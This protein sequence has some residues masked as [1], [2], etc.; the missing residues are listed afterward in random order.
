MFDFLAIFDFLTFG[1]T[2]KTPQAVLLYEYRVRSHFENSTCGVLEMYCF[3]I[4]T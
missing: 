2:F 3:S 4:E 1:H